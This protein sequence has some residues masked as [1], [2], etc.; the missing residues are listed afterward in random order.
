MHGKAHALAL[1]RVLIDFVFDVQVVAV[2]AW[3][4]RCTLYVQVP[5]FEFGHGVTP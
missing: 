4:Q 2:V 1:G 3:L 5:G